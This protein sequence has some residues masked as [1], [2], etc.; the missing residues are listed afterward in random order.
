MI[1]L[2]YSS[3]ATHLMR[4]AELYALLEEA[5]TNN[6]KLGVTG[7]LLYRSGNFLQVLEGDEKTVCALFA[8][9]AQ[10][11][12]HRNVIR[13]AQHDIEE[14]NFADWQ[15][16]FV[17]MDTVRLDDVPGFSS[18]LKEPFDPNYFG[19]NPSFAHICLNTFKRFIR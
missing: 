9:I 10:D 6:E 7:M 16:G 14:R 13:I 15:M 11:E 18:Y 1:H 17:N 8:K 19:E 4:D 3:S 2:I 12:R 5:R